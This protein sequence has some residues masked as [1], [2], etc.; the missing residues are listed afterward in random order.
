L[1]CH[2]E[3]AELG[4][5]SLSDDVRLAGM[6]ESGLGVTVVG[7]VYSAFLVLAN[8]HAHRQ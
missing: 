5:L 2:P 6:R 1:G 8:I 3:H 7:W 4:A